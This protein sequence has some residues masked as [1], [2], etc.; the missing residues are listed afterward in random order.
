M[1]T[2]LKESPLPLIKINFPVNKSIENSLKSITAL[3][4]F[5]GIHPSEAREIKEK[6]LRLIRNCESKKREGRIDIDIDPQKERVE[7]ELS[8]KEDWIK[9]NVLFSFSSKKIEILH[10]RRRGERVKI[11]LGVLKS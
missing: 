8:I 2:D 11:K 3:F 4:E 6:I 7:I 9:R 1:G 5:Y 10:I